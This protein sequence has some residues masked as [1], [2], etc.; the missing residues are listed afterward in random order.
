M[1]YFKR[2]MRQ[3]GIPVTGQ[4]Q[5]GSRGQPAA[6]SRANDDIFSID[7]DEQ[8][9][10][11]AP[12]KPVNLAG[13]TE[14][15]REPHGPQRESIPV[16]RID[17]EEKSSPEH[18]PAP[19]RSEGIEESPAKGTGPDPLPKENVGH[20]GQ[21]STS[22][23]A[24]IQQQGTLRP[25][26]PTK[27]EDAGIP[28]GSVKEAAPTA[29]DSAGRSAELR[30]TDHI[31]K[32][33]RD[34]ISQNPEDPAEPSVRL[35]A[36]NEHEGVSIR[37]NNEPGTRQSTASDRMNGINDWQL[38]I[39]SILVTVEEPTRESQTASPATLA[40]PEPSKPTGTR[41]RLRRHYIRL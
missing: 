35:V 36:T 38:S 6:G 19:S 28:M 8:R 39:G 11:E 25:G 15:T 33:V 30:T 41:S 22:S 5:S 21:S 13:R 29:E 23:P 20:D 9:I 26:E 31:I 32:E 4:P 3:T 16:R 7:V 37:E 17:A 10:V 27:T 14:V 40:R 24:Y 12:P 18:E 34:W 2:I 1:R